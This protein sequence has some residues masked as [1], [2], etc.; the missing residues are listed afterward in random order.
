M[1]AVQ[2]PSCLWDI[3]KVVRDNHAASESLGKTYFFYF[4]LISVRLRKE[5]I[6]YN[7]AEAKW[8]HQ[9][10]DLLANHPSPEQRYSCVEVADTSESG[11]SSFG[12]ATI[13]DVAEVALVGQENLGKD[14]LG[15]WNCVCSPCAHNSDALRQ[16]RFGESF[17]RPCS[18]EHRLELWH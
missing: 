3:G 10:Y 7:R 5:R 14:K 1:L 16:Q 17:D 4:E 2:Q 9:V 11:R 8:F 13:T 18:I 6:E 15:N 12:A